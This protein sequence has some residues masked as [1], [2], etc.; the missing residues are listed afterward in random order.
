MRS[1]SAVQTGSSPSK[2]DLK[3][4]R[5]QGA[6]EHHSGDHRGDKGED[7]DGAERQADQGRSRAQADKSPDSSGQRSPGQK[8]HDNKSR[9][10]Q[11]FC[12]EK[13]LNFAVARGGLSGI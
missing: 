8:R 5:W 12:A 13:R 6:E 4:W 11:Q 9:D 10:D 7:P 1:V 3:P 2:R